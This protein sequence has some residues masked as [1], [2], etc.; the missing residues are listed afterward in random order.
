[1]NDLAAQHYFNGVSVHQFAETE[2]FKR[3]YE[4]LKNIY[5]GNLKDGFTLEQKYSTT[6]DLRPFAHKYDESMLD[7]LFEANVPTIFKKAL[8]HDMFLLLTQV[9]QGYYQEDSVPYMP[10]HRDTHFYEG[11]KQSG[12]IPPVYKIIYYPKFFE[13]E[14][15]QECL[16]F[17]LGSH[18]KIFRNKNVDFEQVKPS[19]ILPVLNSKRD[20]ILFNTSAF[21]HTIPP[22]NKSGQLKIIY[23]FC[24]EHQL[25]EEPD[26]SDL[27]E[28]YKKKLHDFSADCESLY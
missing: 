18:M 7:V 24:H 2:T 4:C 21:H 5:N 19:N 3:F 16:L 17:C 10:W 13:Y 20:F 28:L 11:E 15:N 22:K 8:G 23:S 1:M 27:Q 6:A 14:N 26:Y 9:R 25:E 12:K